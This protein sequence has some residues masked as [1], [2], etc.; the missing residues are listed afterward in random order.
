VDQLLFNL[1][2]KLVKLVEL[3]NAILLIEKCTSWLTLGKR[4]LKVLGE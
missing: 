1:K 2:N 4:L 3:E